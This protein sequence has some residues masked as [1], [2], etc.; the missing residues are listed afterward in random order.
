LLIFSQKS[1]IELF[2]R[3][4]GK[5]YQMSK[6]YWINDYFVDLSRN[7]ISAKGI[8]ISI[9]KKA[10]A[11]LTLLAEHSGNVVSH[12]TIMS[13]VWANTVV[14]PNTLQRSI[15]QLRKAFGDDSKQQ[16]IIK[17]HA[18]QGYSLD[19]SV[20]WE[21]N[22]RAINTI[23]PAHA[24]RRNYML[25]LLVLVLIVSMTLYLQGS[26]KPVIQVNKVLPVTASDAKETNAR[27]SP[28]GRY[29]VFHRY[30]NSY[31]H[32]LWAKDLTSQLEVQLT[33]QPGN[34]GSHSWSEDGNQLAFALKSKTSSD[35][36]S[37]KTCWQLHT[38][39]LAKA[40]KSPQPTVKRSSC[41]IN[42]MAVARWLTNG[43]IALLKKGQSNRHSLQSYNLLTDKLIELY[44]PKNRELYS[45]DFSLKSQTFAVVSRDDNNQHYI[46]KLNVDGGLISSAKILLDNDNSAHEYYNV[47]FEPSG[48]YLLTSTE[49]GLFQ[50]FFD[51]SM[52]QINTLGHRNLSEPSLH[53]DGK[54]LVAIQE[55]GDQDIAVID[56]SDVAES[57]ELL[58]NNP[59]KIARSNKLDVAGKFQP[60]GHLVAYVSNRS[61][62]RQVWLYDGNTTRQLTQL[63]NGL[64][65]MNF[66]WSPK[67][68]YIAAISGDELIITA[69][70]GTMKTLSSSLL[71]YKVMQWHKPDELVVLANRNN[72][73]NAFLLTIQPTESRVTTDT[74]LNVSAVEWLQITAQNDLVY[75]DK[76]R[77]TWLKKTNSITATK[78]EKLTEQVSNRQL[79]MQDNW[80]FG[81][82]NQ[83]ELWRYQLGTQEFRVLKQLSQSA[84]Y[85]SDFN[86]GKGLITQ[87]LRHNKEIV[88]L[89]KM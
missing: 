15:A 55:T 42:R 81:I 28:D 33:A 63:E 35:K 47:Y 7:Q 9:P 29:L 38:L 27:F 62:N 88:T 39:D 50:L 82:N 18:K 51:G 44:A 61:G 75:V 70:D 69:L 12:D 60:N 34:Y 43:Q 36:A 54:S 40:L 72:A 17:T 25:L 30:L 53:P 26:E 24:I 4:M 57:S 13:E 46:E 84:R 23:Q 1:A 79:T 76:A 21:S 56:V 19:A 22:D 16:I 77:N 85:I 74:N 10:L 41:K 59:I 31:D 20:K 86:K 89:Y 65:S 64:Q 52:Q 3:A 73:N 80:L 32:H 14:A 5:N 11:V 67:G 6:Q 48:D 78:I 66:V 37:N 87:T 58:A 71:I 68:D 2:L 83:K 45:Y 8:D 49:L